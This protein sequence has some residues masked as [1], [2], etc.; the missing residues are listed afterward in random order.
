MKKK[1]KFNRKK[2]Y[3]DMRV[4][5]PPV[6]MFITGCILVE[7]W[8]MPVVNWWDI[9]GVVLV[10]FLIGVIGAGI[11]AGVLGIIISIGYRYWR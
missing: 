2:F 11:I 5:L 9:L 7:R 3:K 1:K 6:I 8:F 4:V 10:T